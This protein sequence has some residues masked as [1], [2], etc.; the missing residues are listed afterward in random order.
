MLNNNPQLT[1]LDVSDIDLT[2]DGFITFLEFLSKDDIAKVL[3]LFQ[4]FL[5]YL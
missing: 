3:F 4:T 1:D 2:D 5:H